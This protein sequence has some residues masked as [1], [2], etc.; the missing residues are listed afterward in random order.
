MI[1]QVAPRRGSDEID[2]AMTGAVDKLSCPIATP[3]MFQL[4]PFPWVAV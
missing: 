1:Q 2:F 4:R 3:A